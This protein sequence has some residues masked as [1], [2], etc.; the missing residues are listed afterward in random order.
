MPPS[1]KVTKESLEKDFRAANLQKWDALPDHI[2]ATANWGNVGDS[3]ESRTPGLNLGGG[4]DVLNGM[5]LFGFWPAQGDGMQMGGG[6]D[7]DPR[8]QNAANSLIGGGGSTRTSWIKIKLCRDMYESDGYV[9][10]IVD[11]MADFATEGISFVH[12]NKSVEKFY[13]AWAEQINL[14]GR[15][16]RGIIDLLVSGNLFFQRVY[17]ILKKDEISALKSYTT[18]VKIKDKLVVQSKNGDDVTI[19]PKVTYSSSVAAVLDDES[20]V[21]KR[22]KKIVEDKIAFAVK[23]KTGISIQDDKIP[24]EP[25][26]IPWKYISLNPLQMFPNV[27]GGWSYL[28]T[29]EDVQKLVDKL[30]IKLNLDSKSIVVTLPDNMSGT[31]KKIDNKGNKG[32]FYAEMEQDK[33]RLLVLQLS[34]FDWAKWATPTLWKVFPTIMFKNTLRQ[35]E[36]KTARAGINIVTLWKLGDH[37][38]G[39]MPDAGHFERLA[40]MLK[41]PS[42]TINVLWSSA[43][44]AEVVQPKLDQI[45]DPARWEGLRKETSAQFGITEAITT[46]EGGSFSSSYISVQGL[47]ER[48]NT[49]RELMLNEWLIPDSKLIADAMSFRSLPAIMFGNMSLRDEKAE[50]TLIMNLLDRGF[51]SDETAMEYLGRNIDVERRRLL[52]QAKF[53]DKENMVRRGPFMVQEGQVEIVSKQLKSQE[54]MAQESNQ[55]QEKVQMTKVKQEHEMNM[56]MVKK[57]THPKQLKAI[58]PAAPINKKAKKPNGRPPGSTGPQVKKRTPKPKNVASVQLQSFVDKLDEGAKAAVIELEGKKLYKELSKEGKSKVI[59]LV[60]FGLSELLYV[61][62]VEEIQVPE[63]MK[64][65]ASKEINLLETSPEFANAFNIQ[66]VKFMETAKRK[67]TKEETYALLKDAFLFGNLP[68][69]EV[70]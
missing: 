35:M 58:T 40:D 53:E 14:C 7:G 70:E 38:E 50:K 55:V 6:I 62:T 39:L 19:E 30:D 66:V 44:E 18:G 3:I 54:K 22:I 32:G 1:K 28:L 68:N 2:K 16:R 57:G 31:L 12:K 27:K 13:N 26:R 47:L 33:E 64:S 46:G 20:D 41:A 56:E 29:K 61:D 9:A 23:N 37:K 69:E 49:L 5:G 25:N 43:I 10:S 63:L 60:G 34:K 24:T 8:M 4:S 65:A 52:D 51:I 11:L 67:P 21:P 17:A 59:D 15:F 45:F 48:L 36:M 42:S